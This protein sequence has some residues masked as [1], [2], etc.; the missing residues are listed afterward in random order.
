MARKAR[1]LAVVTGTSTGIGYALA[2]CCIRNGFDLIIA[3]GAFDRVCRIRFRSSGGHP[4]RRMC[5]TASAT[6]MSE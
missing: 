6:D 3:A 4:Q 2:K 5:F 1:S